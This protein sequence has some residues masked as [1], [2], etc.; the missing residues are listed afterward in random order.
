MIDISFFR[1][2]IHFLTKIYKW[3]IHSTLF[4]LS[5]ITCSSI[6]LWIKNMNPRKL[7]DSMDIHWYC[8]TRGGTHGEHCRASANYGILNSVKELIHFLHTISVWFQFRIQYIIRARRN[9]WITKH[10][11]RNKYSISIASTKCFVSWFYICQY[12]NSHIK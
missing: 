3:K 4:L 7:M 1:L 12:T 2:L 11:T 10:A 8:G 6:H 9:V 5:S